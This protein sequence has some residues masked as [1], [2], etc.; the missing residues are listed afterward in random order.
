M[1]AKVSKLFE[2]FVLRR[3]EHTPS[4]NRGANEYPCDSFKPPSG[5]TICSMDAPF[6]MDDKQE[7]AKRERD[8]N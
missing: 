6:C 2:R 3:F 4:M 7:K 8:T 1:N 5:R